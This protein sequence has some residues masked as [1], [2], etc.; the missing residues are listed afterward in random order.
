[1]KEIESTNETGKNPETEQEKRGLALFFPGAPEDLYQ[2]ASLQQKGAGVQHHA[3]GTGENQY[4]RL[5]VDD[6]GGQENGRGHQA[7]AA[8]HHTQRAAQGKLQE[9]D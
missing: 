3:F 8:L 2:Q 7:P 1:M 4:R 5:Q 9:A 6:E